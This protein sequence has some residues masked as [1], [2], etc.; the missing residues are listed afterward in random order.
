MSRQDIENGEKTWLEAFNAGDAK[1]VAACYGKD[2]RLLPPNEDI[3]QGRAALVPFVQ[4]YLDTGAKLAFDL[5]EVYE[6]HDIC[7]A[8]GRYEMTVPAGGEGPDRDSGK[9][10]EVW[11]RQRDGSWLIQDDIFNSS[12]PLPA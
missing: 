3:V 5:I 4:A 8:V 10:L 11:T 7:T 9:Y 12:L 1:G 2:A 6:T